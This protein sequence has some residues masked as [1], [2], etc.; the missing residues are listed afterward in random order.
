MEEMRLD[1]RS[2]SEQTRRACKHVAE[3]SGRNKTKRWKKENKVGRQY[4]TLASLIRGLGQPDAPFVQAT[5]KDP[6]V[7]VQST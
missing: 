6:G 7:L 2:E 4:Q 5:P 1:L 3:K